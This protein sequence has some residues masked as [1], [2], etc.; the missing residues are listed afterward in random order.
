MKMKCC[1]CGHE[2]N[3]TVAGVCPS[4]EVLG[5]P[6]HVP[7]MEVTP[8][9]AKADRFDALRYLPHSQLFTGR[10]EGKT[11]TA[12]EACIKQQQ[13]SL[14]AKLK[15]HRDSLLTQRYQE[16]EC[17]LCNSIITK[18]IQHISEKNYN[19][20]KNCAIRLLEKLQRPKSRSEY[21]DRCV[22][23]SRSH[24]DSPCKNCLKS[25]GEINFFYKE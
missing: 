13:L 7:H 11:M 24:T 12:T 6:P 4:C 5:D 20:C 19:I 10:S 16:C 14:E 22:F 21:C 8:E 25:S 15:A 3:F 18:E 17:T 1:K 2:S 9:K 23:G